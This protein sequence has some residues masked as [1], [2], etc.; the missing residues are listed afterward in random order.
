LSS[1]P[2]KIRAKKKR[3]NVRIGM[4]LGTLDRSHFKGLIHQILLDKKGA[5]SK[6]GNAWEGK[7]RK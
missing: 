7:V 6:G 2:P 1:L 5:V 3:G 4:G